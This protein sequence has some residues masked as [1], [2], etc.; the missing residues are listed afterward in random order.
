MRR[1][2]AAAVHA[3]GGLAFALPF[4]VGGEAS[5]SAT[6]ARANDAPWLMAILLPLLLTVA[7]L[8]AREGAGDAR[9]VALA[10]ALAGLS[11]GLRLPISVAGANLFF[12][13]PILSGYALGTTMGFLVGAL[14]MAT[15]ALITGGIGPWLPFQMWAAGWVGMGAGAVAALTRDRSRRW[16]LAGYAAVA[17][18]GYGF[19]MNLYFWPF[20]GGES[21]IGWQPGLSLPQTAQRYWAFYV[22][23]GSL[24]W[25]A[26][27]ATSTATLLL[28]LGRP[29]LRL[30][31]RFRARFFW[32]EYHGLTEQPA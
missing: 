13:I 17:V 5:S 21:G 9:R 31:R 4:L 12:F 20:V 18:M 7:L 16:T 32:N 10:G 30:L 19:L 1:A 26:L 25:D 2:A 24:A 14:G 28:V 6:P 11:A 15:S 29:L 27:R 3:A 22:L 8:S 23:S